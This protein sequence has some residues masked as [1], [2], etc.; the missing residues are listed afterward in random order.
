M[1]DV[2]IVSGSWAKGYRRAVIENAVLL[3]N[4]TLLTGMRPPMRGHTQ[5][6]Q[7]LAFT[8]DG[9]HI[10]STGADQTVCLGNATPLH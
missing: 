3:P 5:P 9:T 4:V 1:G 6:M 7:G 10:V 8:P 2:V